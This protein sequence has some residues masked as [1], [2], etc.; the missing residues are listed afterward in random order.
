M[1][2]VTDH[3]VPFLANLAQLRFRHPDYFQAGSLHGHIDFRE[4]LLASIGSRS[5]VDW[6]GIVREGVRVHDFFPPF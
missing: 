5:Q 1:R 6:L 2:L 3:E 4:D